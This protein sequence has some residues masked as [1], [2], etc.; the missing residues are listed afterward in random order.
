MIVLWPPPPEDERFQENLETL[1]KQAIQSALDLQEKLT[2]TT[3]EQG[4]Q[5]SVKIGT[6]SA[7]PVGRLRSRRN[8]HYPC[9]RHLCEDRVFGNGRSLD[10]GIFLRTLLN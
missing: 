9:W 3:I 10:P 1:L 5:L 4:I 7:H 2:K 8:E 6:R